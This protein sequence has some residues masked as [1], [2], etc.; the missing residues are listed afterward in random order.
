MG[1]DINILNLWKAGVCSPKK[2]ENVNNTV[3]DTYF[4]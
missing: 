3:F 2:Q 1:I 4:F